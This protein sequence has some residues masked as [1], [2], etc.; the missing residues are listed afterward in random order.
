[1]FDIGAL[2]QNW[3]AAVIPLIV[4][5]VLSWIAKHLLQDRPAAVAN[6]LRVLEILEGTIK[7]LLG[8]KWAPVFDALLQAG[9]AAVDGNVT[10]EEANGIATSTFDKAIVVLGVQL[11]PD[12]K[13][14]CYGILRFV[15][16]ALFQNTSVSKTAIRSARVT[17]KARKL[18]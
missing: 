18:F 4:G 16:S 13:N 15:V 11:T 12:E 1:M 8:A 17:L 14:I 9:Q 5:A 7:Q 2:L 10:I 6:V 3:G